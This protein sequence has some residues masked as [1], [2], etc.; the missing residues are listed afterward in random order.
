M[1]GCCSNADIRDG[2]CPRHRKERAEAPMRL[3]L[4]LPLGSHRTGGIF[5]PDGTGGGTLAWVEHLEP[6]PCDIDGT[7]N[8]EGRYLRPRGVLREIRKEPRT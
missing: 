3:N 5:T 7:P 1:G 4:A 6:L 8:P 2:L